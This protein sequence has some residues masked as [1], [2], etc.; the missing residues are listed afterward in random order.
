MSFVSTIGV[1]VPRLEDLNVNSVRSF[2][3]KRV[4]Y[5][6]Q[7]EEYN[8]G[9]RER[10]QIVPVSVRNSIRTGILHLIC[11]YEL[12]I[13]SE[14]AT[15]GV[16]LRFL[17][18][19]VIGSLVMGDMASLPELLKSNIQ[20][21]GK[22]G[23]AYERV[24]S[25][26]VQLME[27]Q[28]SYR[29]EK[30]F[31]Q[32]RV[33]KTV[34]QVFIDALDHR[35]LQHRIELRL[36]SATKNGAKSRRS[37]K[38]FYKC[39]TKCARRQDKEDV[40]SKGLKRNRSVG[41]SGET[42][43][44]P[45]KRMKL[46]EE[47]KK[48]K[49]GKNYIPP[50]DRTP[51]PPGKE[52]RDSTSVNKSFKQGVDKKEIVCWKCNQTGHKVYKCPQLPNKADLDAF[53]STR[54]KKPVAAIAS[55]KGVQVVQCSV[56]NKINKEAL[57]DSGAFTSF[58]DRRTADEAGVKIEKTSEFFTIPLA[59]KG[60][61]GKVL[62]VGEAAITLNLEA[63]SITIRDVPIVVFDGEMDYTLI[64]NDLLEVLG[65]DPLGSLES[66]IKGQQYDYVFD[67]L[68]SQDPKVQD[69]HG[70][71]KSLPRLEFS[72]QALLARRR[73]LQDPRTVIRQAANQARANS[74]LLFKRRSYGKTFVKRRS[75]NPM[76]GSAEPNN[77]GVY[78]EYSLNSIGNPASSRDV[79][80]DNHK[81]MD[82]MKFRDG[83]D[84]PIPSLT[85][86]LDNMIS[87]SAEF[88]SDSQCKK[89]SDLV[90]SFK[91]IWRVDMENDNSG[92]AKVEPLKLRPKT[93]CVPRRSPVRRYN[94]IEREFLSKMTRQLLKNGS[95]R[96]NRNSI[97]I[98][99]SYVVRKPGRSGA[100]IDHYRWTIDLRYVNSQ[101]DPI[102]GVLPVLETILEHVSGSKV[103]ASLDAHKGYWQFPLS[104]ESQ[105]MCSFVTHEGVFTPSRL[106][107]GHQDSVMAVVKFSVHTTE[108]VNN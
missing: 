54:K 74:E 91:D 2:L 108:L 64:G 97:W 27:V 16:L 75:A 41:N 82:D 48:K 43:S 93:N 73:R 9:Y 37:M 95:I 105:E 1:D 72:M 18:D 20:Y 13:A 68:S 65:I 104:E 99:P 90:Y 21:Y 67:F 80:E 100:L 17:R 30:T 22:N 96:R 11:D 15:D 60:S 89:L 19:L 25:L 55:S 102:A 46:T 88:L 51:K 77:N 79:Y 38:G 42:P 8:T 70:K 5:E 47:Q 66:K 4:Q 69:K 76:P 84:A 26:W 7:V 98:S 24:S 56:N 14:A 49:F 45:H 31:R 83:E 103:Y 50:A 40:V 35:A 85:D 12:K 10:D 6:R 52:R 28:E 106:L 34:R 86:C 107:Q 94:A 58:I 62:G 53:L 78:E 29:L 23:S 59:V 33:L 32:K 101:C 63:G 57:L 81:V 71:A 87:R 61:V 44:K 39:V 3:A 36:N 92:P